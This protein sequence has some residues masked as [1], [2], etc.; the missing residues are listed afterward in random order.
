MWTHVVHTSWDVLRL[1]GQIRGQQNH[2]GE[3]DYQRL[4]GSLGGQGNEGKGVGIG[5]QEDM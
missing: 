3:G 5:L 2:I 4:I 1:A